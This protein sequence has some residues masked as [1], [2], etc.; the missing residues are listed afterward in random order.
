VAAVVF[1]KV[2]FFDRKGVPVALAVSV[3][4]LMVVVISKLIGGILPLI[5]RKIGVDPTVMSGPFITSVVDA[6]SLAVYFTVATYVLA[7]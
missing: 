4:I 3:T 7:I 6:L 1:A 5:A 2:V